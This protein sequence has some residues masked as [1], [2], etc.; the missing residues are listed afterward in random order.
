MTENPKLDWT[1]LAKRLAIF[2]AVAVSLDLAIGLGLAALLP[3]VHA[4]QQVGVINN[5]IDAEADVVILGSSHAMRGFDDEELTRV[6]GARVH[7]AGLDGRGVLFARG[8]LALITERHAPKLVVLDMT[9]ADKQRSNAYSFAPFYGRSPTVDALLVEGDWRERVKLVS[10]SFRMNS[11]ALAI[12]ANLFAEHREWGFEPAL[13]SLAPTARRDAYPQRPPA[14]PEPFVEETLIA[15]IVDARAH[16]ARVVFTES[17]TYGDPRPADVRALY[18]RVATLLDVPILELSDEEMA[19]FGPE[20]FKDRGHL[21]REGAERF[22]ALIGQRL[23]SEFSNNES[24][25]AP[26]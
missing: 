9:F 7:N 14:R 18:Q 22:T 1:R 12:L 8:M 23:R 26:K 5:A 21:N 3:H 2:A 20:Q 13:G 6:L 24:H 10:R 17:P 4:G 25:K 16:G 15:L 11:V 19:S